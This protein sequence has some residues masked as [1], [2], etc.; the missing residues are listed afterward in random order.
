[1]FCRHVFGNISCGFRGISRFLGNFAGFR[2]NT[3][4]SRVR[5]RAKYQKPCFILPLCS[6]ILFL[7]IFTVSSVYSITIHC[8]WKLDKCAI[9][10]TTL[11]PSIQA[12]IPSTW[13]YS[14]SVALVLDYLIQSINA[15]SIVLIEELKDTLK[16][17][18]IYDAEQSMELK[19]DNLPGLT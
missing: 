17:D 14:I 7:S 8:K 13:K 19:S 5:D 6:K 9:A 12:K 16:K 4:I 1:M 2:G 18:T 11:V 10:Y 15:I 3:W